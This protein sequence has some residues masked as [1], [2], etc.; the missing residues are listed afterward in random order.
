[1]LRFL[2]GNELRSI[3]LSKTSYPPWF[4]VLR[5]LR[6]IECITGTKEGCALGDCGA[7]TVVIGEI[8]GEG[9]VYRAV[10]ACLMLL[11]MI[12]GKQLICIEHLREGQELHLVQQAMVDHY[13]SQCGFCTPGMVMSLFALYKQDELANIGE[14]S[15]NLAGNLCRCTGYQPILEAAISLSHTCCEDQFN[16]REQDTLTHLKEIYEETPDFAMRI[17]GRTY[18]RYRSFTDVLKAR[19]A[20]PDAKLICGGTDLSLDIT[21][22]WKEL[23]ALIDIGAATLLNEI[24]RMPEGLRV[25]AGIRLDRL[26]MET[27]E[28]LP[29]LH[30]VIRTFGS[31]QIRNLASLGGNINSASPVSDLMPVL[32]AYGAEF[33][34]SGSGGERTMPCEEFVT[35]Y[36]KTCMGSDE[37]LRSVFIP[38]PGADTYVW[39]EK[40]SKRL[41]VDISSVSAGFR[42]STDSEGRITDIILAYGGMAATVKRAVN[43]ESYLIGKRSGEEIGSGVVD[44]LSMDFTPIDDARASASGRMLMAAELLRMFILSIS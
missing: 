41:D 29:A 37:I 31:R 34:L 18:L 5:Y 11:P 25:G 17:P 19:V 13:G 43:A 1:M 33:T 12:H 21:K 24:E 32:I 16:R 22:A 28:Y 40:L 8:S 38:E 26:E 23:P 36:R 42:A 30:Q 10:N 35:G 9:I 14:V 2:L 3:D 7:C 4:T 15:R 20:I 44:M 27:R 39:S 6:E